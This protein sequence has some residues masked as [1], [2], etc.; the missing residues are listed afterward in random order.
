VAT[1]GDVSCVRETHVLPAHPK[2]LGHR[3]ASRSRRP[4]RGTA[5]AER[6]SGYAGSMAANRRSWC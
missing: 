5:S 6:Q 3:A 1:R 4:W 2:H